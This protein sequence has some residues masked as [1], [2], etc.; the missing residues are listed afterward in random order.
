MH[1]LSGVITD[2]ITRT[3]PTSTMPGSGWTPARLRQG[4]GLQVS[5]INDADAAGLAEMKFGAG[6]AAGA[7]C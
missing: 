2:G 6:A 7:P 5:M 4:T 3:A 1:R